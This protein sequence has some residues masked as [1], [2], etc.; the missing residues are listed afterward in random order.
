MTRGIAINSAV[1]PIVS[2]IH[3]S[4]IATS[5]EKKATFS[6]G[7]DPLAARDNIL[8]AAIA[9]RMPDERDKYSHSSRR[10]ISLVDKP[11]GNATPSPLPD[12][13]IR[14]ASSKNF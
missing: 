2:P 8:I 9:Q 12:R 7:S 13:A 5:S 10:S 14:P 6:S 4:I 11:A 1:V 3:F